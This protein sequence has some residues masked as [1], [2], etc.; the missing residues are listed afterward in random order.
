MSRNKSTPG[1]LF[2]K[3]GKFT[4]PQRHK[5]NTRAVDLIDISPFSPI[6]RTPKSG[7]KARTG[8]HRKSGL[9]AIPEMRK[10]ILLSQESENCSPSDRDSECTPSKPARR[11]KKVQTVNVF[12]KLVVEPKITL[13]DFMTYDFRNGGIPDIV[14]LYIYLL[15]GDRILEYFAKYVLR[16]NTKRTYFECTPQFGLYLK[17][18]L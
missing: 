6:G 5:S 15:F 13:S 11:L 4:E 7:I 2:F 18:D 17:H 3:R 1:K 9:L 12:K 10:N 16:L 14:F 8:F